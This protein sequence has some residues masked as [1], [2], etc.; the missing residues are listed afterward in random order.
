LGVSGQKPPSEQVAP[1][2]SG[3]EHPKGQPLFLGLLLG[4]LL[5]LLSFGWFFAH[6]FFCDWTV[7]NRRD[8]SEDRLSSGSHRHENLRKQLKVKE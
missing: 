7:Q 6:M 4:G 1:A 3:A 2:I 8:R 5:G